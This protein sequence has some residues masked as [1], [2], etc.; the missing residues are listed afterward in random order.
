M[1]RLL[2]IIGVLHVCAFGL[3][4]I[5]DLGELSYD[6]NDRLI[7]NYLLYTPGPNCN[8]RKGE[9]AYRTAHP[10]SDELTSTF[11]GSN[12]ASYG[13][14]GAVCVQKGTLREHIPHPLPS[15]LGTNLT[16]VYGFAHENCQKTEV[17]FLSYNPNVATIYWVDKGNRIVPVGTLKYGEKNTVWQVSYLGHR[18]L[19]QDTVT[20]ATLLELTVTHD[21]VYHIGEHKSALQ[22][23]AHRPATHTFVDGDEVCI[24]LPFT[25]SVT[26]NSA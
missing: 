9:L 17:G 11:F 19:I 15:H 12:P 6:E 25:R 7:S 2:A 24:H 4:A 23:S 22:V 14:C 16:D 20:Q 8:I 21:S 5:T 1:L 3:S 18:F 13:K 10:L 26:W